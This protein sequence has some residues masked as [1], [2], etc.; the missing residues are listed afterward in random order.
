MHRLS[1]PPWFADPDTVYRDFSILAKYYRPA[2]IK[3][4]VGE[5]LKFKHLETVIQ[6]ARTTGISSHF[7]L[8]T[9]GTMI[10]R[11][12]DTARKAIDEIEISQF[13]SLAGVE[14]NICIA[15]EKAGI[16]GKKLIVNHYNHSR[17][18]FCLKETADET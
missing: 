15:Q 16:F 18:T 14:D 10:H 5:S 13:P 1:L 8:V 4:I 9:R 17:E 11:A 7:T 6:A 3:I 12:K 2:F